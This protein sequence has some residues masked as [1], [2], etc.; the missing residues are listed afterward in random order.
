M[1]IKITS[2][3]KD[4]Q[5]LESIMKILKKKIGL[6]YPYMKGQIFVKELTIKAD[7]LNDVAATLSN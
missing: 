4:E 5:Q 7:S 1:K 3:T 6:E 2:N